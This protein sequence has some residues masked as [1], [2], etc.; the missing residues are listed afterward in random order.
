MCKILQQNNKFT[1]QLHRLISMERR[2][3]CR[4]TRR[5][6]QADCSTK[7]LMKI[8]EWCRGRGCYQGP[9]LT[10]SS[11]CSLMFA[12]KGKSPRARTEITR[13]KGRRIE[14]NSP[15][16][17]IFLEDDLKSTLWLNKIYLRVVFRDFLTLMIRTFVKF[18]L[19]FYNVAKLVL[20]L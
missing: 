7:Y 14:E 17:K 8:L 11:K 20:T 9:S 19:R 1:G 6:G 3:S 4:S 18:F 16:S 13:K 10:K 2:W 5:A 12:M 15:G